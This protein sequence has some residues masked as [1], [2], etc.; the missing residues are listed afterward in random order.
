MSV[1][2]DDVAV[3]R[4]SLADDSRSPIAKLSNDVLELRL[5]VWSKISLIDGASLTE[6]TVTKNV[7]LDVVVPSL[8]VSV[9]VAVPN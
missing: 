7:S 1:P 3:T 8:T 2:F 5:V 9:I 6:L 4:R